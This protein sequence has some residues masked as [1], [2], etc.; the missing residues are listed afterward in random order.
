MTLVG[1][2]S[3]ASDLSR[4]SSTPL[5]CFPVFRVDLL[6]RLYLFVS[7]HRWLRTGTSAVEIYGHWFPIV[8]TI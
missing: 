4:L 7:V 6:I 3:R 1:V 5:H 2:F 8:E